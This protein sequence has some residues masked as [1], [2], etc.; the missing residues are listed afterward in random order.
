[1]LKKCTGRCGEKLPEACFS[2]RMWNKVSLSKIK[3]QK[4]C[5]AMRDTDMVDEKE[6][7]SCDRELSRLHF[8]DSEWLGKNGPRKCRN[9]LTGPRAHQ[10]QWTCR[11]CKET[12]HPQFFRAWMAA[13]NTNKAKNCICNTCRNKERLQE[14]IVQAS[15]LDHV[16]KAAD[17]R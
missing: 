1:M 7:Q 9:C 11:R 16:A 3:C 13:K 5:K 12:H 6:C 2:G 14:V 4:C 17:R 8:T 15:N 10:G